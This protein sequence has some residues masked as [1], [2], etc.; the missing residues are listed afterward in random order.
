VAALSRREA[1]AGADAAKDERTRRT[2]AALQ[3]VYRGAMEHDVTAED[4]GAALQ[5]ATNFAPRA[6]AIV[7]ESY[8]AW[9]AGAE[10]KD[11][12]ES[13]AGA[14]G[15]GGAAVRDILNVGK[16]LRMDWKAGVSVQSSQCKA[17]KV[18]FVSLVLHVLEGGRVAAHPVELTIAEFQVRVLLGREEGRAG[19]GGGG[20]MW[21][22][23]SPSRALDRSVS[24]EGWDRMDVVAIHVCVCVGVSE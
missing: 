3:F 4:L 15:G 20:S 21:F 12:A 22:C 18:P 5:Q 10:T 24:R 17:L 16:L 7:C 11:A 6:V 8:G 9:Q 2:T 19:G 13:K 14:G 1:R 23:E